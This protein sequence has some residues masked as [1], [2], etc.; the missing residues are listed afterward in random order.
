[1]SDQPQSIEARIIE[2][3]AGAIDDQARCLVM[4]SGET[5]DLEQVYREDGKGIDYTATVNLP[6]GVH[7]K[8]NSI[9]TP[10]LIKFSLVVESVDE[11]EVEILEEAE[12][13]A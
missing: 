7:W 2:F 9:T 11:L 13:E 8:D 12:L 5:I 4:Q 3:F 10:K 1:M 6:E